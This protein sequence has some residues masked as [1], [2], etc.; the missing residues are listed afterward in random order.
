MYRMSLFCQEKISNTTR[1]S[2]ALASQ[3][4]DSPHLMNLFLLRKINGKGQMEIPSLAAGV[5]CA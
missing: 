1:Q 3:Q 4:M 2:Q 5:C